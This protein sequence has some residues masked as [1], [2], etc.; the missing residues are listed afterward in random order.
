MD[1]AQIILELARHGVAVSLTDRGTI[2]CPATVG[3]EVLS[4]IKANKSTLVE[5]LTPP[6]PFV[7][8]IADGD[9]PSY[10][11]IEALR[12]WRRDNPEPVRCADCALLAPVGCLSKSSSIRNPR[13]DLAVLKNGRAVIEG[14][15]LEHQCSGFYSHEEAAALARC[16]LETLARRYGWTPETPSEPMAENESRTIARFLAVEAS[17]ETVVSR[18]E[19]VAR[20]HLCRRLRETL[21]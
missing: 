2:R 5:L 10:A 17:T 11:A 19:I 20:G 6:A 16:W 21:L 12:H 9:P 8:A 7:A 1:A 4:A 15:R 3:D 14:D 18:A 13:R